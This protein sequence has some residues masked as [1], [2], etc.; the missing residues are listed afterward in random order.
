MHME[1]SQE[2]LAT[3]ADR[4]WTYIGQVERGKRNVTLTTILALAEALE[5]EP[6]DLLS[7]ELPDGVEEA[8][9]DR[10]RPGGRRTPPKP[11]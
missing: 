6:A 11:R 5:V 9:R 8:T 4:H 3:L 2:E 10:V 1:L 7:E